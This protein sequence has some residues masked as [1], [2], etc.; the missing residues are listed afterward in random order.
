MESVDVKNIPGMTHHHQSSSPPSHLTPMSIH[1]QHHLQQQQQPQQN[2]HVQTGSP[3]APGMTNTNLTNVTSNNNNNNT[4]TVSQIDKDRVKRPMNAFMVWSRGQRRKM[5]QE[6]PKMHNSE[7]SKRLGAEWK[8]LTEMEKRPFIDEAKRLRAIHMKDYP[9]YKYRPRR[10]TKTLMKKDKYALP[11]MA[12][13]SNVNQVGRDMYGMN[14]NGYMSNGYSMMHDPTHAYQQHAMTGGMGGLASQYSSYGMTPS[15]ASQLG[16]NAQMTTASAYMNNSSNYAYS[17]AP[18]G[19][20]APNMT[21]SGSIKSENPGSPGSVPHT[22]ER[23]RC[24]GEI[25]DMISVYLPGD[26]RNPAS[27]AAQNHYQMPPSHT[28]YGLVDGQ[29]SVQNTVPLTHM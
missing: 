14:M 4:K 27:V 2:P 19:L 24:Q 18:Y 5:A 8:L 10:K 12:P 6:N 7:I 20:T 1:S 3:P 15:A 22:G 17:M 11:G 23:S 26:S 25:K 21:S 9:D 29:T 16:V 13:G 28:P